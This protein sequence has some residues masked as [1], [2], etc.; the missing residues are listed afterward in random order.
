MGLLSL[1]IAG[2]ILSPHLHK[3]LTLWLC[4]EPVILYVCVFA[5]FGG[6]F[7]WS[8]VFSTRPPNMQFLCG[9]SQTSALPDSPTWLNISTY[10]TFFY[11][12]VAVE[13][14]S[15]V[16]I[17]S[18]VEPTPPDSCVILLDSTFLLGSTIL[19]GSLFFK[20]RYC[21]STHATYSMTAPTSAT[22]GVPHHADSRK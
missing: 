10:L 5:H 4:M 22:I 6:W 19:L 20:I 12:G 14:L 1:L 7:F 21:H 17:L 2:V 11:L 8:K 9:S 16:E 18:Q 15:Q 3:G 13:L